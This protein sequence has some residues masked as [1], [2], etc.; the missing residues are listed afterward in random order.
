[1]PEST[2][3]PRNSQSSSPAEAMQERVAQ[4]VAS[5]RAQPEQDT[6]A[7]AGGADAR[8][9]ELAAFPGIPFN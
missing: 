5:D 1:M 3:A 2:L 8:D 6:G 4:A 9:D 7:A